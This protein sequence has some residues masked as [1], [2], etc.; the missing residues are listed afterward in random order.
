MAKQV[1]KSPTVQ[2]VLNKKGIV[3]MVQAM[4]F[5]RGR[6]VTLLATVGGHGKVGDKLKIGDNYVCSPQCGA[7]QNGYLYYGSSN[8]LYLFQITLGDQTIEGLQQEI[9]DNS[10]EVMR[11]KAENESIERK[12]AFMKENDLKEYDEDLFKVNEVLKQL[13]NKKITGLEKAKLIAAIIKGS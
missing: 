7:G 4:Q 10:E 11:L 2:D 5:L 13:D 8:A 3:N 6:V 9:N 1:V 12:I